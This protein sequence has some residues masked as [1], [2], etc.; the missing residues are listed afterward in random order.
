MENDEKIVQLIPA[1]GWRAAFAVESSGE[2]QIETR[3]LVAWGLSGAGDV[4]A[5]V[6]IDSLIEPVTFADLTSGWALLQP[7][8][9]VTDELKEQLFADYRKAH[10][11]R[12]EKVKQSAVH[13]A[14]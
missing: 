8:E 3:H 1:G 2:L 7:D 13:V 9:Q 10:P 4:E 11:A 12:R 14:A 6:L 5:L